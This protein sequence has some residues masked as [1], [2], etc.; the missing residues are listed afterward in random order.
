ML[1]SC[2]FVSLTPLR[3]KVSRLADE[4]LVLLRSLLLLCHMLMWMDAHV[5]RMPNAQQFLLFL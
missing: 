1:I 4:L 2:Y 5:F 3:D